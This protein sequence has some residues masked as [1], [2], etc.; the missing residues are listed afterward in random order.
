MPALLAVGLEGC[1][2]LLLC[3]AVLPLTSVVTGR[4]GL[5]IDDAV[6]AFRA[7]FTNPQLGLAVYGSI[8]S[9]AFFNF[10]GVSGEHKPGRCSLERLA[11]VLQTLTGQ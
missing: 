8:L 6:A 5:P 3:A 1:W 11:Q 9:I 10:F 4:D 2:G 7:I